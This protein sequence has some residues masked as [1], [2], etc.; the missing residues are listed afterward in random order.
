METACINDQLGGWS[1]C[2][3]DC[4]RN[5]DVGWDGDVRSLEGDLLKY[6]NLS[7]LWQYGF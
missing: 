3:G 6:R 1:G 7:L 4:A 5:A 2:A